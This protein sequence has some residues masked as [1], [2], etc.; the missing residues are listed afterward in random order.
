MSTEYDQIDF[1]WEQWPLKSQLFF[2]KFSCFLNFGEMN[3]Q[4]YICLKIR[5]GFIGG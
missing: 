2:L 1:I 3:E 4:L 5:D